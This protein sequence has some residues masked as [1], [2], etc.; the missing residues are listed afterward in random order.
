M[1]FRWS[2]MKYED[3]FDAVFRALAHY[4]AAAHLRLTPEQRKAQEAEWHRND[5][6]HKKA[7]ER[8]RKRKRG[9]PK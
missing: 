8:R 4:N 3:E 6:K 5:P 1:D 9:G 2:S 7:L